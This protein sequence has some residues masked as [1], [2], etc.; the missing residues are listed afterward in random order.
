[1]FRRLLGVIILIVSLIAIAILLGGAYYSGQVVDSVAKSATN[2]LVLTIETLDTVALTLDQ[3]RATI[4]EANN[5]IETAVSLTGNIS[6]T[7]SNTQ[8]VFDSMT[9]V[10]SQDIPSNIE[11]IQNALPNVAGVAG[12]VDSAMT[13]LSNFGIN[14]TIPIPFNPITLE[15]DLGIEYEP[16]E[17]FDETILSLGDSLEGMPQELRSLQGDLEILSS[18]LGRISSDIQASSEDLERVNTQ[19]AEFVPIIDQYLDL[20]DRITASLVRSQAQILAQLGTV[21]TGLVA[22]FLFLSLT[23]IA[24]LFLGWELITGQRGGQKQ[25]ESAPAPQSQPPA[26]VKEKQPPPAVS[27][28]PAQAA[29]PANPAPP[30]T[31]SDPAGET[32]IE[33]RHKL[34]E[35][36]QESSSDTAVKDD[37]TS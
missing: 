27:E 34:S 9:S 14:Q 23:Q 12:V 36:G 32:I 37:G 28:V 17:P 4:V 22:A 29:P 6:T 24:P 7:I 30:Q 25:E 21:K 8:P 10:V 33:S 35:G 18:D 16:E 20:L 3:T 11:A 19:V 31:V 13:T 1:M 15:F 5:S 26:I 2:M